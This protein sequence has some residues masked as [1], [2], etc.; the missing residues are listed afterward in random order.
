MTHEPKAHK[1]C[2]GPKN[3]I[4]LCRSIAAFKVFRFQQDLIK[5]Y[6]KMPLRSLNEI[7][8]LSKA[9]DLEFANSSRYFGTQTVQTRPDTSGTLPSPRWI[10]QKFRNVRLTGISQISLFFTP[11]IV[12]CLIIGDWLLVIVF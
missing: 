5:V 3:A 6:W 1:I 7:F 9:R 4:I 8:D 11:V 2:Y 10:P 12:S